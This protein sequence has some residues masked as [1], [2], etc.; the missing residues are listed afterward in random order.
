MN[1]HRIAWK[2]IT[3]LLVLALMAAVIPAVSSTPVFAQ[4]KS[5]YVNKDIN[6]Q[7][8]ISAY[9]IKPAPAYLQ[10]QQTSSPTR[11]GGSGLAI[12]TDSAILFVTFEGSGTMDIVDAQTLTKLGQVTAPN[13]R[14]LAGIV[15]DQDNQK[16]YAVDRNTNHLYVYS[17]NAVT[18]TLTNDITTS[19]YYLSLAGVTGAHGI[20]LDEVND[21]LYIGDMTAAVKIFNSGD[22]S[23]AGSV[24]VT[25]RVQGVAIDVPNQILYTGNSYPGYGS[26]GLLSKYDL[27]ANTETT[28]NIRTLSGGTGDD[29]VVGLAVDH[30]TGLVYITTGNQGVGGSDRIIVF[31]SSL[32]MLH[33][34]GDI[35]N[36][37]GIVVPGKPISY[38][39]LDLQKT[40]DVADGACVSPGQN[41]NYTISYDNQ[42]LGDVTNV[43]ITD[44][45]PAEVSYV[46]NTGGGT[47]SGNT[48]TW[49]IGTVLTG[50]SGSV[51]LT[52]QVNTG[53]TPGATITNN[54]SIDCDQ[55]GPA[56]ANEDT[57]VC[58]NQ[59]PVADAGADQTVEQVSY[60]GTEVTLD[61]SLSSDDGI[62]EPLTYAWAWDG[63]TATGVNPTVTLNLGTHEIE[64]TVF[65]GHFSDS[66]NVVITVEDTTAPLL[67]CVQGV[68]PHG[69]NVPG[70]KRSDNKG[71]TKGVNPDGFYQLLASDDCNPNLEIYI[72]YVGAGEDFEPFGPFASGTV[73]K[74]TEAPGKSEPTCKKIGSPEQGGATAVTW[75][76]TL[77]GDPIVIVDD[78]NGNVTICDSC[79]VPPPPK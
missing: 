3:A 41:I 11:Y 52:V 6:A 56:F 20:A 58:T 70:E 49:N 55:T 77:P 40:D 62:L 60:E 8:P 47:L 65:D 25:Q 66:D 37:T 24:T 26:I 9:A 51:T 5:L 61:G 78:L 28:V 64:L 12:D 1:F 39:P 57:D 38:N 7:S 46:S 73:I 16:V 23:S 29:N 35:G 59:P 67:E 54:S 30:A 74:F 45:L 32:N 31:D 22:W 75:H 76:I 79:L 71:K 44:T 53:V 27:T 68:N 48:V 34:T 43:T 13:A 17:W 63:G 19:P 10:W 72:T 2:A 36:P 50:T 69:E 15:V 21:L 4:T 33:A 18:K 42:N 14:N